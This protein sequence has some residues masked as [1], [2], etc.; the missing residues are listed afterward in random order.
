M[1]SATNKAIWDSMVGASNAK[2]EHRDCTVKALTAATGLSYD[3]CH[4]AL[5]DTGRKPRKGCHWYIQGPIAANALGFNMRRLDR[6]EYRC[7]TMIT[8][9]KDRALRSGRF[10]VQVKRHVAAV[11]DGNVVDWSEGTR[12]RIEDIY[13]CTPIPGYVAPGTKAPMRD[14]IPTGSAKWLAFTKYTKK[15]QIPL[16]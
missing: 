14:P 12:R 11:V 2:G 1:L 9:A 10:V 8:A 6:S 13:E 16:F 15:D 4:K 7:K 5:A 3:E